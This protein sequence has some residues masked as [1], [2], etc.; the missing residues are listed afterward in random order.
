MQLNPLLDQGVTVLTASRRL[1]HAA[2]RSYADLQRQRGLKIWRSPRVLPLSAW[3]RQQWVEQRATATD[4]K[5]LRLLT[6]AQVRVL[7]DQVVT[8]ST[9]S[10]GLLN[11][12]HAARLAAR[13]WQ[14]LH[15]YLIP[16]AALGDAH[17]PEAQALHDWARAF[18][19]E[20]EQRHAIDETRLLERAF[21]VQ[22]VPAERV[23]LAG[24]DVVV[25]ALARLAEVWKERALLV[26]LP[27]PALV[28]TA[29]RTVAAGDAAG[30]IELAARWSRSLVESGCTRVGIVIR[31]LQ[32]RQHEVRRVF[33]DVFA[34]GMRTVGAASAA[35]PVTVA[36]AEP[37]DAYPLVN[38]AL[39]CWQLALGEARSTLV[40]RLLRS[41]FIAGSLTEQDARA[42]SDLRLREEQR[43]RW[44]WFELERWAGVTGCRQLQTIARAMCD[45]LRPGLAPA[46]ASLWSERLASGLKVIGW[47]GERSL[48]SVEH[49]TVVKFQTTLAEFG[50]LDA[51][52]GVLTLAE[53]IIRLRELLGDTSFEPEAEDEAVTVID[54]ATV[55]GMQ[56]EAL[57]VTGLD[58]THLPPPATPDPLIPLQ[59][60][61]AA[62]I[63]EA[64]PAGAFGAGE[65]Q[66]QQLISSAPSVVLSWPEQDGDAQLQPSPLLRAWP[67]LDADALTQTSTRPSTRSLRQSL[68]AARP[69]LLGLRDDAAPMVSAERATGGARI[70]ELQSHCAF[71]AQAELRLHARQLPRVSLGIEPKDRGTLLHRVLAELWGEMQSQQTLLSMNDATLAT[72]VRRIAQHQAAQL[73]HATTAR[74]ARLA[75]LEID[76]VVARIAVLLD[77]ERQRAPFVVRFAEQGERF[78][79]GGL[80]IRLQPDRVDELTNGE[81]ILLDY[82]LG[83]TGKPRQWLDA[84]PGRPRAP[85]LPLYALAHA[86]RAAGLAFVVLA[87]GAVEFRGWS[88]EPGV[89]PG[90]APYPPSRLAKHEP[91]N[92]QALQGHWQ[93]T[94][95]QLA[96]QFVAG[97]AEVDPLP[98]ACQHCHLRSFCRIHERTDREDDAETIDAGTADE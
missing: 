53:A 88:R 56:F 89:A 46:A 67:Q 82:K 98:Q 41:P 1:A 64:S 30:E 28:A 70:L 18:C 17:T 45:L 35:I 7:W 76:S 84:W 22:R 36:A 79:I 42:L 74:R 80:Q 44:D 65:A 48:S 66:L 10:G 78:S 13:S 39:S 19:S 95:R 49:Q 14:R 54:A 43:D 25:P 52:L 73:L 23:A 55:A 31:D 3:L 85:Q 47:P 37:L 38:A 93:R 11:P 33:G 9:L 24:F 4:S 29:V 51:V 12:S 8:A 16:L 2:R 81:Q 97:R 96:E 77:L 20:C 59:L 58:A 63:P 83:E 94:L 61:R 32:R 71:R 90:I 6:G 92:W 75:Q 86:Q 34:P 15:D 68:F 69:T 62:G 60:Q 57:W 40:G 26:E 27:V 72:R 50:A 21:D 87:P 5:P 91:P